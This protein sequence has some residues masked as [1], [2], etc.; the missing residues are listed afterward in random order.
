MLEWL[1]DL[2]VFRMTGFA[3]V[4]IGLLGVILPGAVYQCRDG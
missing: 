4:V 3:A 2:T 1:G